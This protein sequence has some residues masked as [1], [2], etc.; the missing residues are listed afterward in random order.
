M[1]IKSTR[2]LHSLR[3]KA[4]I[5]G[6]SGVGK[7]SLFG[8]LPEHEVLIISAESG[9][10]C[11]GDKDIAALEITSWKEIQQ[12]FVIAKESEYKTIGVDSLTEIAAILARQLETEP[13]Y[14]DA[15]NAMKLWG[16]YDRRLTAFI[17][18][19]RGLDKNIVLTALPEQVNDSG[20]L[21][22]KPYI[23]G[24]ATQ[25]LL[26]SYFDEVFYLS[27]DAATGERILQTQPTSNISAKDR[28]GKLA[29]IEQPDLALIFGKI[30]QPKSTQ[31]A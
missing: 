28:S 14:K 7:T 13:E 2:G 22:L 11:L 3:I 4:I 25:R 18:A 23:K 29:D 6:A 1:E 5:Y 12:A 8:T 15:R 10:L 27:I 31:G 20:N 16:E 19:M 24:Q 21:I 9:L 26:E 17:K 30:N